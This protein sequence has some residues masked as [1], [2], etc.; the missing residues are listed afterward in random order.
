MSMNIRNVEIVFI[1]KEY[2]E[3]TAKLLWV[4]KKHK[5]WYTRDK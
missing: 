5:K 3:N 4:F 2:L 1:L